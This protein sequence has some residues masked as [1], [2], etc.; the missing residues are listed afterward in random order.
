MK[1]HIQKLFIIVILLIFVVELNAQV[2]TASI[3][4]KV[5]DVNREPVIGA[6]ILAIHE[7]SGTQYGAI[8][9]A[10]GR[11]TIQGMRSGGPYR[12]I[13]SFISMN[14]NETKGIILQLGEAFRH[15]VKLMESTE[16]L[17]E[18]VIIGKAGI[19]ATKTGAAMNIT[20]AEINR[21]PS[22]AHGIADAIRMN[23]QVRVASD[24]AMHFLGMNNRYNSFQIDGVMNN[25][26][27][28]L[29][30]NGSNG[31]QAGTQPVSMETI[32]QIQINVAP[33]DIR[34]SGFTGGSINAI[35]KSGTNEFHGTIYGFG[36]NKDLIGN[37]YRM[38]DGKISEKYPAQHEYQAGITLG[39]PI[40]KNKL[41]FFANYEKAYKTFHNSYA[42]GNSASRID[43][44]TATAILQKL[45]NMAAE[46]GIT[47]NGRLDEADVYTK[48]D[49][50]G[51]KLDWN[52]NNK[53]K[54]SFRWSLVSARQVSSASSATYLN[55]SDYSYDFISKTNSFVGELQSR[56]SDNLS[57]EMRASYVRVRDKR[58]PDAP[59]PMIQISNVG[60]GTLNLGN[61]R[62]SMAN[63]LNE[64]IWSFT[65]NLTWHA[66]RHTFILGT[67]NEFYK[68]S[69]LFIQDAY[70]SYFFGSPDDFYAG[71]IKQY[72][73][74]EANVAITGNPRWAA[75]FSA[76]TLGF[77]AQ[78]NFSVTDNL[79]LTL[80]VRMDIPL[81]FDTPVENAPFNEFM[82]SKGWEYKTNSKLG[83]TPLF[84]PRLGF[85]WN[86]NDTC[87]YILRG[88]VGIFT[89]RIPF[90]WLSN[91][92]SNT[93]IQL[94]VYSVSVDSNNPD[95]TKDLSII[96][97]PTKQSQNADKLTTS[98]SQTINVFNKDFKF[99]QSL[100]ANLA[101]DFELGGIE[102]TAEAIY[103]RR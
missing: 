103:Q 52:M 22:I 27:Y 15:D 64:D 42:I 82:V 44:T 7:S 31:G 17:D 49:K 77:Y 94:S 1:T 32:E 14:S 40:I 54:A 67:H 87:R 6:N 48:S 5:T 38:M 66:G 91:N 25:D 8:T 12:V 53:H 97:D 29:S 57:N 100:R 74:A 63:S 13:V 88:G 43:A 83:S 18:I 28:G 102:W 59:F 98:G 2:T 11:Y 47:Y 19:D 89:G 9:N 58:Q 60:D 78:D 20:S 76:S 46:Q 56:L 16:L 62:S 85:R 81:F 86:M 96:L 95:A 90:V 61:D 75:A 92:F 93:G 69:N 24:G 45:Q 35:T 51:F 50:A 33:F 80:G 34:Q 23:P 30:A 68:F 36:N 72:R 70:G 55:S 41:F 3:K 65:D 37:K 10:E 84:S 71:N 39:G 99:P 79:D 26:V 21:M 73:F 4:G 101:V